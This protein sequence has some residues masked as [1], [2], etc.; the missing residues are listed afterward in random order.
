MFRLMLIMFVLILSACSSVPSNLQLANEQ[1]LLD[2]SAAKTTESTGQLV[3]W[4][5]EIA[6]VRNLEQG[7][8]IEVVEFTLNASGRPIK[9]DVSSGRFRILVTD[10]IDP[11]IYAEGREVTA[12]GQFTELET[13]KVGDQAYQFPLLKAD[14][15]HLWPELKEPPNLN[16]NCDPFF[17][18]R[19]FMMSPIIVVPRD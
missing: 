14:D 1:A 19:G 10:F 16:C 8:V 13:G 18:H 4:G 9:S 7:S 11:V 6:A 2:F 12:I 3:R 17:F 15:V 5:G